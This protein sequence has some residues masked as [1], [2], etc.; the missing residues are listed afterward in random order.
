MIVNWL[1]D[2]HCLIGTASVCHGIDKGSGHELYP[3]FVCIEGQF[4]SLFIINIGVLIVTD[5]IVRLSYLEIE[6][7]VVRMFLNFFKK[8]LIVSFCFQA[9]GIFISNITHMIQGE[10]DIITFTVGAVGADIT[11]LLMYGVIIV[12]ITFVKKPLH[13][14][15]ITS[16]H[17]VWFAVVDAQYQTYGTGMFLY[18]L[19]DTVKVDL[20][21][22]LITVD[23]QHIIMGGFLQR[24]VPGSA[25]VIDPFKIIN[26]V[27]VFGSQLFRAVCGSGIYINDLEAIGHERSQ[28]F[29]NI[30]FFVF[31]DDAYR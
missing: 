10:R 14:V 17:T 2:R 19:L 31:T 23:D 1:K 27:S 6:V 3:E 18:G 5:Q 16:Q 29:F 13:T 15:R 21:Q 25:E 4:K 30:F 8:Q 9:H 11:Y 20:G 26:L 24:K 7:R 22:E 12:I 28:T